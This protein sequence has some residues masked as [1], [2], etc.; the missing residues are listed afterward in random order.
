[1]IHQQSPHK[2][3]WLT[4]G[5]LQYPGMMERPMKRGVQIWGTRFQP[6]KQQ[7]S[8]KC[9]LDLGLNFLHHEPETRRM[10]RLISFIICRM[11]IYMHINTCGIIMNC[12][13][14]NWSWFGQSTLGCLLKVSSPSR[15]SILSTGISF[16]T[17]TAWVKSQ[18]ATTCLSTAMLTLG[19]RICKTSCKHW[20]LGPWVPCF[21]D[22][23]ACQEPPK[24]KETTV[25]A[26]PGRGLCSKS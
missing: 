17:E 16:E 21:K 2:H 9:L 8:W 3:S 14:M 4:F 12:L 7:G 23:V 11:Y 25:A 19:Q 13:E 15:N 22:E 18:A 1:M 5:T 24:S 20:R 26:K 10:E 6:A